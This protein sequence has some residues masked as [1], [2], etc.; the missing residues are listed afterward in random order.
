MGLQYCQEKNLVR[1]VLHSLKTLAAQKM[2]AVH[3]ALSAKYLLE[4]S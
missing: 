4:I 3:C 1:E 2:H